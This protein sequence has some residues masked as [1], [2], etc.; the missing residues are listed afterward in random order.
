MTQENFSTPQEALA[1]Y[2]VKGMRWG[3]TTKSDSGGKSSS[4]G[5]N[6]VRAAY[7][8][9]KQEGKRLDENA[10]NKSV[11]QARKEVREVGKTARSI[12]SESKRAQTE[13]GRQAAAKRYQKEVLNTI[14]SDEFKSTYRK[15]STMGKGEMAAHAVAFGPLALVTIPAVRSGYKKMSEAGYELEVD[16]AHDILRE[17]RS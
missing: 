16:M 3:V 1:H 8:S 2:G 17:M 13:A 14:K 4:I 10:A 6:P 15:A 9:Q 5:K 7:K 11:G 12:I